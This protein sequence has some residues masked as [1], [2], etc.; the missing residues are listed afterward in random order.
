MKMKSLISSVVL[1]GLAGLAAPVLL[2][3]VT[4]LDL[5]AHYL[6]AAATVFALCLI[7]NLVIAGMGGSDAQEVYEDDVDD[8][9]EIG[10]VKWFNVTKGFGF[11]TRDQGDDIFVHFRSIRGK[12][13]RSL[14]EGQRVKF[15]VVESDKGLQAEDVSVVN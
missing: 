1:S 2:G 10:T 8:G 13:H 9:R 14:L 5:A 11:I 12:G 15:V 7:S 3:Q 4:G 6:P